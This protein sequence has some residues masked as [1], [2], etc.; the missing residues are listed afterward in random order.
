MSMTLPE[1]GSTDTA[2]RIPWIGYDDQHITTIVGFVR[3]S[4]PSGARAVLAYERENLDRAEVLTAADSRLT[5][6]HA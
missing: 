1:Q 6:W 2:S 3:K 4:T 5:K